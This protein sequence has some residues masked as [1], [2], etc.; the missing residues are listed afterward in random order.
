MAYQMQRPHW[1][2]V[3]PYTDVK[4]FSSLGKKAAH[5]LGEVFQGCHHLDYEEMKRIN[6][7]NTFFID[8][9][10]HTEIATVDGSMMSALVV[11]AHD[12]CMRVSVSAIFEKDIEWEEMESNLGQYGS[13]GH[14]VKLQILFHERKREGSFMERHPPLEEHIETLRKFYNKYDSDTV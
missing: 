11:M 10:T 14:V 3:K 1:E 7:A 9:R 12:M 5:I 8:Y 6:W 2:D 4:E 13:C